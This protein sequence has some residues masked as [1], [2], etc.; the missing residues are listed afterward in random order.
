MTA[1]L[2]EED[3]KG[4]AQ[5]AKLSTKLDRFLR[6]MPVIG[7]NSSR[8]DINVIRK[9]LFKKIELVEVDEENE[10][11]GFDF[12]IK[13][14]NAYMCLRTHRLKFLDITNYLAPGFSYDQFLKAYNCT[15]QKVHFPYEWFTGVDKLDFDALPSHEEFYSS[16]GNSNI[17][18]VEVQLRLRA[19]TIL[20]TQSA[21]KNE[22]GHKEKKT[23]Q[24]LAPC[25]VSPGTPRRFV[26]FANGTKQHSKP[27]N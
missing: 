7:F 1:N 24:R 5:L 12:V 4:R 9:F 14:N 26:R 8:Y 17:T 15:V 11:G 3:E 21:T 13:R 20:S 18:D 27:A 6:G 2:P 10:T 19:V 16:L 25:V 23:K 22:T